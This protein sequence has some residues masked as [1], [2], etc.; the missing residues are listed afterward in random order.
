MRG[1]WSRLPV[2]VRAVL[3]GWIVFTVGELPP[4]ILLLSANPQWHPAVPW[5]VPLVILWLWIFW[6]YVS[7]RWWPSSTAQS[8]A[9]SLAALPLSPLVW[10]WALVA[11]GLGMLSVVALHGVLSPVTPPTYEVFYKIFLRMPFLTLLLVVITVSAV[12]GIVEEAA[13][14]GYVQGAIERRHGPF[15]AIGVTTFVFVLAH[16]GG[17]QAMSGPRTLF[18]AVVSVMYGVLRHLTRSILPGI[19]LH[20]VGDAFSLLLLWVY[21]VLGAIGRG[22]I[23]FAKA[24]KMPAFWLN[25]VELLVFTAASVWAFRKLTKIAESR[26]AIFI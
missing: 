11:G 24:S 4:G 22:P 20:T 23:G 3:V 19:I 10:R 14:R 17:T 7:G 2:F 13:F 9:E 21:W 1:L 16:F 12:A 26:R 6:Q 15:V 8:R 18:I 25:V 5:S